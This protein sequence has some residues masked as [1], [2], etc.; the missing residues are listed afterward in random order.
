MSQE[1]T[2]SVCLEQYRRAINP[3]MSCNP[4]GH[5]I[6]QPCIT[7]WMRTNRTCPECRGRITNTVL[8]RSLLDMIENN[9]QDSNISSNRQ[10]SNTSNSST[11]TS[12]FKFQS[13]HGKKR[14][15][16]IQDKSQ[17]AI[18]VI[19][20]SESMRTYD[21]KIFLEDKTGK[22]TKIQGVSRWDEGIYKTMKS[23]EYNINRG[24]KAG[25]YLL[26]PKN[27]YGSKW[28]E[29]ID[30]IHIDPEQDNV[31]DKLDILEKNLLDSQNIRG[32]TPLGK[33]TQY[34][35]NSL[36]T[37]INS[38][39]YQHIPVCLNF[40]T[41]GMPNSSS[42][43]E[44][45]LRY[46]SKNYN[47]FLVINLCT[48]DDSIVDYYNDLDK[49]LGTELSG[50][51]VIDDLEAEQLEVIKAG[52]TFVTYSNTIHI[53]RMAGC[54]SVV[55]DLLDEEKLGI[56]YAN[57]L[58]RELLDPNSKHLPQWSEDREK[59]LVKL[60]ELNYQVYDFY[61]KSFRPLIDVSKI[62]WLIWYYQQQKKVSQLFN[63]NFNVIPPNMQYVSF[64][65]FLVMLFLVYILM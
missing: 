16:L 53:C 58:C 34:C 2:C 64:I 3:P 24:M 38:D 10:S 7:R 46:L 49:K 13:S 59:Y 20:N 39:N 1:P 57:K 14:D 5:T 8:N 45:Q 44:S 11:N 55:S 65:F 31:T 35:K 21:G 27:I 18:Y 52:N 42:S 41:D 29:N 12:H 37:F 61:Y 4:C 33:I 50:M 56:F 19:D 51:D 22:I 43:F 63:S 28:E 6:C 30:C 32:N 47:I 9:G 40:I 26:N 36:H 25:Y 62:D 60:K 15:E 23:A 48:D 54:Y 17:Y